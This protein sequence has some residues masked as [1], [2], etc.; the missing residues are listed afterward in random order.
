MSTP[1]AERSS[2]LRPDHRVIWIH[3]AGALVV[4]AIIA[5]FGVLGFVGGLGFFDTEGEPILGMSTNG[6]LST[7]SIV[8]AVVLV[9]AAIR[10]GRLSSTVMVVIGTLFLVSAFVNLALIGTA[11]NLL[12]FRLPNVF[13]SIGAGMVLLFTGAYGRFSAK[14]PPDNPYKLE[15]HPEDPEDHADAAEAPEDAHRQPR[16]SSAAE[17]EAD[18]AM[19]EAARAR[20]QG[21]ADEDQRRRLDAM[22]GA[23]THEERRAI[24]MRFDRDD[25]EGDGTGPDG[26]TRGRAMA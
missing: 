1:G 9:A 8:T 4:A 15:R 21:A 13:F 23:R 2:S 26:P 16:P 5:T 14:L 18:I 7:V 22:A 3:R 24:W 10:G 19:A 25:A 12:A 6:A 17:A 11:Y 20:A